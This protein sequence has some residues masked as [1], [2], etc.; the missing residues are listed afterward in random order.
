MANLSASKKSIKTSLRRKVRNYA[1]RKEVRTV[2]KDFLGLIAKGDMEAA[3]K[4]LPKA[5]SAIDKAVKK[6]IL[7]KNNAA[8]KKSKLS[9]S[10][11]IKK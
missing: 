7:H 10:L 9:K 3:A 5:F 2:S 6:N 8:R 1:V 4:L 11:A